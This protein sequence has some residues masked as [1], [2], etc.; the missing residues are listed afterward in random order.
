MSTVP[1]KKI[2]DRKI[3]KVIIRLI[4]LIC[5]FWICVGWAIGDGEYY[6]TSRIFT[7]PP[8][9]KPSM[10]DI[11][12]KWHL[13][14]DSIKQLHILGY[15]ILSGEIEFHADGTFTATNFP[16]L[17]GY[18]DVV[19]V[20]FYTG[21]G[22]WEFD[23]MRFQPWSVQLY[24]DQIQGGRSRPSYYFLQGQEPP[25]RMWEKGSSLAG[26]FAFEKE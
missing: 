24:Y 10:N 21:T 9:R 26:T 20:D 6:L 11:V 14:E 23:K 15:T 3:G 17:S 22:R 18:S 8:R 13:S 16:R 2:G 19:V 4:L 1:S 5:L 12:G 25:F 7:A